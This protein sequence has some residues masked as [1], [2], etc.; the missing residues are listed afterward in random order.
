MGR[1]G[2]TPRHSELLLASWQD[3][4]TDGKGVGDIGH[5]HPP[6]QEMLD[7]ELEAPR[8]RYA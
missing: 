5:I 1:W 3:M 8:E 2:A 6:K 4:W 7:P